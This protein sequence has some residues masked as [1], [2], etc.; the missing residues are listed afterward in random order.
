MENKNPMFIR[1]K[2]Q[3]YSTAIINRFGLNGSYITF[4]ILDGNKSKQVDVKYPNAED[5]K[6]E[7]EKY[8][9]ILTERKEIFVLEG[10]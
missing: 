9:E 2:D 3:L 1:L 10:N 5:A 6:R 8:C 7:F 4:F